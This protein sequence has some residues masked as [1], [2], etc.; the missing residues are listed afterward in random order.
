MKRKLPSIGKIKRISEK[1]IWFLIRNPVLAVFLSLVL[2]LFLGFI[3]FYQYIFFP[4]QKDFSFDHDIV[5]FDKRTYQRVLEEWERRDKR[6]ELIG[7]QEYKDVFFIVPEKNDK[8]AEI[9]VEETINDLDEEPEE[10]IVEKLLEKE[11][12]ELSPEELEIV[13]AETLFEFYRMRDEEMPKITE[14]A[15]VWEELGLGEA[16]EYKGHYHQN[17]VLLQTLKEKLAD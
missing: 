17:V 2:S 9:P 16:G 15:L 6:I 1:T 5:E 10:D 8:P 7:E 4:T 13:L 14:R 11:E 12:E 3:I